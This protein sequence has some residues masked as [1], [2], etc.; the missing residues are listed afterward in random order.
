MASRLFVAS[1][2]EVGAQPEFTSGPVH[3][4]GSRLVG[5]QNAKHH[6]TGREPTDLS[7]LTQAIRDTENKLR[8]RVKLGQN[9]TGWGSQT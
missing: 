5:L 9:K 2:V 6:F 1:H 7:R 3:T 8:W 4:M